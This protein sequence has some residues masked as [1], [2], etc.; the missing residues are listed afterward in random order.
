VT[1]FSTALERGAKLIVVDPRFS[2]AA[3]KADWWLPIRPGSDIALLL[4][5]MNVLLEEGSY[6]KDYIARYASG[7]REVAAHVR[8]FTPEWAEG[9]TELP[10]GQIRETARAMGAAKPAVAIHPGRHTT[11]YGDDTQRARA[12]AIITALLGSWGRKGGIFLPTPLGT[13]GFPLPPFPKPAQ[14]RADGA[15]TRYPLASEDQGLTLGLV[16]AT[17]TEKP[18][19]IKGWIVYGQNVLESIPQREQTLKAIG[20]L[21]LM[22]VVDVMPVEQVQYA[23]LVLPEA[24]YLERYDPPAVV[25]SAKRPFIAVRQPVVEPLYDSRPG[26]WI[27]R[28]MAQRLGLEAYF[29]W[30]TPEEHLESIVRPLDVNVR[31]LRVRGAVAFAGRP[32]IENRQTGDGP[33]FATGSGRIELYSPVRKELGFDPLPR[34]TQVIDPPSGYFRLLYGRAPVHSFARSENNAWLDAL[35]P[36]NQ[37]WINSDVAKDLRLDEDQRVVLE[38]QDGV[39]SLPVAVRVTPGIRRDCVYMVHGFGQESRALRRAYRKGASDTQLM[40]RISIDPVMVGTGMRVNFVRVRSAAE[41][42]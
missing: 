2:V 11:W 33:L 10:A 27:A 34:Y 7:L 25:A 21:D 42:G 26:W 18:Y 28:Q 31:Q 19:P 20:K 38:N 5:W 12:M 9:I 1:A 30:K 4:A 37:V 14:E 3:A 32:Y 22:V 17:L 13:G 24:T 29:P 40:T 15:G 16:E 8:E 35:M 6:D 41:A 39:R 23:D 36:E